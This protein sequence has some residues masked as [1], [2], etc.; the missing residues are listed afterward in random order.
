MSKSLAAHQRTLGKTNVWL[1]PKYILDALGQFDL[2][3]CAAPEPK[4]WPTASAHYTLPQDGL[5]LPWH[6]RVWLNPPYDRRVVGRFIRK[7]SEHNH[8]T[9]ILFSRTDIKAFQ[10]YVFPFASGLFFIRGRVNF[11]KPDGTPG[12]EN[13][14]A[15][16][17]LISYGEADAEALRICGLQGRFIRTNA[18]ERTNE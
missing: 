2:D 8:G 14:G 5:E 17:M 13:G 12:T 11:C 4:P 6:G 16:S 10:D 3:P 7:M 9:A 15:P 18:Q 1:T